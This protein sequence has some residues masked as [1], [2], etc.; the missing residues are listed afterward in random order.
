[1]VVSRVRGVALVTV[2]GLGGLSGTSNAQLTPEWISRVPVGNSLSA[3]TAGI[4]VDPDG[5]S[6]HRS[7]LGCFAQYRH[8]DRF[9]CARQIDPVDADLRQPGLRC[10]Y[11]KRNNERL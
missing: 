7:N 4:Y 6:R 2:V 9:I 8:N 1:M 10:G 5:V 3:G 11:R